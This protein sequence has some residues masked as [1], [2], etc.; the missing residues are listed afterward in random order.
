M[1]FDRTYRIGFFACLGLVLM[2]AGGVYAGTKAAVQ[3]ES[4]FTPAERARM[5]RASSFESATLQGLLR[6]SSF[7]AAQ[8][9]ILTRR[10]EHSASVLKLYQAV[11]SPDEQ[12][13][14]IRQS[15]FSV[16]ELRRIR[17]ASLPPPQWTAGATSRDMAKY[18]DRSSRLSG[19]EHRRFGSDEA[20][21]AFRQF[22]QRQS[23]TP[24]PSRIRNSAP[25]AAELR[26]MYRL[27]TD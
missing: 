14:I 11:H 12:R 3:R 26:M 1:G 7:D 23:V 25:T 5:A 22:L 2:L 10:S 8:Q 27:S 16:A 19:G 21:Q 9:T 17:A 15:E 6:R 13:R 4:E 20:R 18:V 24:D